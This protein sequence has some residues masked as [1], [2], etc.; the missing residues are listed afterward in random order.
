[1]K[2]TVMPNIQTFAAAAGRV[3]IAMIF[4]MAGLNEI[5]GDG[6]Q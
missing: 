6:A 5:S 4:V 1:M 3:L 2:G